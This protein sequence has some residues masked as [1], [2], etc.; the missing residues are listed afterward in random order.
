MNE[1][2]NHLEEANLKI[3]DL[4]AENK[5]LKKMQFRH[6]K[7][8]RHFQ[9]KEGN[10]PQMLT[11]HANEVR[12]LREQL[13]IVKEKYEKTERYLRDAEDDLERA[14]NKLKKYKQLVEEKNLI[15]RDELQKKLSKS[16]IDLEEKNTRIKVMLGTVYNY[17]KE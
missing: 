12:A 11:K 7:A 6:E 3:K 8:L 1:L 15:D 14:Q 4:L 16:E 5:I 9:D 2:Q 17:Q 13:K 10:L